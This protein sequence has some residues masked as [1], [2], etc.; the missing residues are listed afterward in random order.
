MNINLKRDWGYYLLAAAIMTVLTGASQWREQPPSP[1]PQVNQV[2]SISAPHT[3][4]FCKDGK[5]FMGRAHEAWP[6][7]A[8]QEGETSVPCP[9]T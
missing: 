8:S 9:L 5:L 2:K 7:P 6:A 3:F 4:L 1:V